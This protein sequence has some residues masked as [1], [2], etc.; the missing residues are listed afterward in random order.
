MSYNSTHGSNPVA[1]TA[2]HAS[3]K[4][5]LDNNLIYESERKGDIL[6]FELEKWKNEKPEYIKKINSK[7]L[8]AGV[9]IESPDG[10]NV[11]FVDRII[12]KAMTLGLMS[13]RTQSGTLKIGPPLTI[14]DDALIEGIN[15]LK[16]SLESCLDI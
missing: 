10:N 8:V 3:V 15:V 13:I 16:E 1:V 9:F 4:F 5:L 7:G 2:S 12:E 14:T 6:K 11:D